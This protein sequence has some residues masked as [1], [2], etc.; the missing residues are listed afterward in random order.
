MNTIIAIPITVAY[1]A[2]LPILKG[3]NTKYSL[4]TPMM[5]YNSIQIIFN[6]YIVYGLLD[7]PKFPNIFGLNTPYSPHIQHFIY[8]HY[9]SK[10]LDY[11]DT[12]FIILRGKSSSQLSFLHV[13]HHSTIGL[14]WAY[15]LY[16]GHGNGTAAFGCLIN[17]FIH[18]IMYA[19]YLYTSLGYNNPLKK[20]LTQA[21]LLQFALCFVHSILAFMYETIF[22]W[23]IA[24]IQFI[25]HIQMMLLFSNFYMKSYTKKRL[26]NNDINDI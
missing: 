20:Y 15:L 19:H 16:I 7:F 11:F 9:L 14:V 13:Y 22:P 12:F 5:V 23:P 6:A 10:Y 4:K 18:V 25:Y 8:L 3:L 24:F 1:L 2:S 21:Q 26:S 17:S